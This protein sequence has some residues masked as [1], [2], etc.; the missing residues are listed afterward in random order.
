M[1]CVQLFVGE[2]ISYN[3]ACTLAETL[4]SRYK[5]RAIRYMLVHIHTKLMTF[6]VARLLKETKNHY[7]TVLFIFC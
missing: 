7:R 6:T 3:C 5:S 1:C 4:I 2:A